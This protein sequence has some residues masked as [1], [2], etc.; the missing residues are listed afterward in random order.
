VGGFLQSHLTGGARVDP[1]TNVDDVLQPDLPLLA[2]IPSIWGLFNPVQLA[3]YYDFWKAYVPGRG[4]SLYDLLGARYLVAKKDTPLDA[5][6]RPAF[7]DDKTLT[8]YED[9][10]PLPRAFA[11]SQAAGG[12]HAQ[13]LATIR[14]ASFDPSRQAVLEGGPAIG[15][16]PPGASPAAGTAFAT[17]PSAS[18]AGPDASAPPSASGPVGAPASAA[19]RASGEAG[20]SG[21]SS[22]ESEGPWPASG[23]V[24]GGDRLAFDITL[25]RQAALVVTTPYS[26]GWAARVDGAPA[27]VYRADFVF[28]GLVLP[29]GSHHVE[30]RFEPPLFRLGAVISI[31]GWLAALG[32][33]AYS[34]TR[35]GRYA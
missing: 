13:A 16:P 21:A 33:I 31:L 4:S 34:F 20:E 24:D 12:T 6:F 25:P 3:D 15:V 26:P 35:R 30:L 29:P 28:Q 22:G 2:G 5:K 11:V 14:A 8:V 32:A 9:P 10:S 7:T 1:A 17:S 18:V 27:R 23:L 19:R